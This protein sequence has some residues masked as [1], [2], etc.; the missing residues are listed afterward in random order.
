GVISLQFNQPE[1]A[2]QY[3]QN[4]HDIIVP[5]AQK[6]PNNVE[7]QKDVADVKRDIARAQQL[8]DEDKK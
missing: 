1:Q 6:D 7:W 3:F 8:L 5:I 4:A 2:L